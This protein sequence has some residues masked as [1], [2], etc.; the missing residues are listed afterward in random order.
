MKSP[1]AVFAPQIRTAAGSFV[2]YSGFELMF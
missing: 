1:D 2:A